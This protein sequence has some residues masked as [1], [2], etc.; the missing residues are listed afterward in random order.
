[1]TAERSEMKGPEQ[2]RSRVRLGLSGKLLLLTVVFMMVAEVLIFVPSIANFR[3]AWLSDRL[4][5][6]HTAALVLDASPDGMISEDLTR[7]LLDSVGAKAVAM[8]TGDS[9]RLLAFSQ[10]PPQT[11]HEVDIR[12][13]SIYRSIV[14][15]FETLFSPTRHGKSVV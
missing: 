11:D 2:E 7:Q 1:M 9:R 12:N 10:M 5:A 13:I 8:K 15:A 4:A 14:D 3:L 6:A